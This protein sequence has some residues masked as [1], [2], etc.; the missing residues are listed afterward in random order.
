LNSSSSLSLLCI[1]IAIAVLYLVELFLSSCGTQ[2]NHASL[3][4]L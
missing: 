3:G 1:M 4:V 2:L